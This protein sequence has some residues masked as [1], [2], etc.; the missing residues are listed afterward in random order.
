MSITISCWYFTFYW[1]LYVLFLILLRKAI[2]FLWTSNIIR[3]FLAGLMPS[4]AKRNDGA[5]SLFTLSSSPPP[6]PRIHQ[7]KTF[8]PSFFLRFTPHSFTSSS[9]GTYSSNDKPAFS[10]S[11]FCCIFTIIDFIYFFLL[12]SSSCV[13]LN[14]QQ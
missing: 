7:I 9:Q 12:R 3:Y 4:S 11:T 5:G 1:T 13:L 14:A 2:M 8:P 6:P 10:Y